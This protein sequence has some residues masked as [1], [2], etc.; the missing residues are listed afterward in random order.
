[1]RD[2]EYAK[3]GSPLGEIYAA[4]KQ[5]NEDGLI[6]YMDSSDVA[7]IEQCVS[8]EI[9]KNLPYVDMRNRR[10]ELEEMTLSWKTL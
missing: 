6:S 1:M 3:C 9:D 8:R 4:Y 2:E 5:A 7:R 10:R